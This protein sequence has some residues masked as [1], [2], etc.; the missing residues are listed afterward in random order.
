MFFHL[1]FKNMYRVTR[2]SHGFTFCPQILHHTATTP[3]G[4]MKDDNN[5]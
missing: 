2:F 1:K 3:T 4:Q 5:K